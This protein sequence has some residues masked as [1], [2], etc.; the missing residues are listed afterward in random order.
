MRIIKSRRMRYAGHVARMGEKTNLSRLLVGK[1]K[2]RRPVGKPRHMLVDN[3]QIDLVV[4][5]WYGVDWIVVDQDRVKWKA[6]E[7]PGSIKCWETNEWLHN[8]RAVE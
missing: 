1:P 3:I 2:E 5:G 7:L 8:W 6:F 4:I